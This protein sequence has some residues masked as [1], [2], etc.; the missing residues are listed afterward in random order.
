M[1][2]WQAAFQDGQPRRHR[3]LRPGRLRRRSRAVPRRRRHPVRR[4]GRRARRTRSWPSRR[5]AARAAPARSTCRSTSAR[6]PIALQP[7]GRHQPAAV[8]R[9]D[10]EDLQRQ[11]QEVGRR[12][13]QGRQPGREAAQHRDHPRAPLG[14]LRH[15]AEL[16]RLPEQGAPSS[17]TYPAAQTWPV[18]GGEAAQGTSGVVQAIK[19]GKG[20]IGYADD[21]Q[22]GDL[23]K[24]K[25]KVGSAFVEPTRR[26]GSKGRRALHA[27]RWPPGRRPVHRRGARH[28]RGRRLPG[29]PDLLPDR[30]PAVR[31][32]R[33]T[34]TSSRRS[35]RT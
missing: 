30:L 32:S 5:P 7:A 20:T 9:H 25:V 34:A 28:H 16:H 8:G 10:R 13:D 27:D 26:D 19:Q 12:G 23:G 33:L 15:H 21:S 14:R 3:Q 29:H 4:L 24:V 35:R 11:D 22:V 2:A 31:R 17:W 18:K 1:A 6:S